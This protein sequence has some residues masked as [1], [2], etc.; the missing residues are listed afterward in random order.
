MAFAD[1]D[2]FSFSGRSLFITTPASAAAN[3]TFI[4]PAGWQAVGPWPQLMRNKFRAATTA[5]LV[6]NLVV[7]S[8][9]KPD[10]VSA[11]GFRLFVTPMG[12]WMA[13]R[14][15]IIKILRGIVPVYVSMMG[16]EPGGSYSV[17]LLPSSD[18]GGESYR[19]SFAFN[20]AG[21][22]T[23]MDSLDWGHTIAH[24]IFHY[25]NGWRLRGT[26][27]PSSQWFQEGF[28]DYAAD[29]AMARS[30]SMT[31][32]D[33]LRRI[34]VEIENYRKLTTPLDAPGTHKG[35]PLY[36]GGSLVALCWDIQIRNA[37]GN[38]RTLADF[39]RT[40]WQRSEHGKKTYTWSD[41]RSALDQTARLDWETFYQSFIHGQQKLP[42]A[43]SLVL[44][45]LKLVKNADGSDHVVIDL[46]AA[47]R[48][49]SL[50]KSLTGGRR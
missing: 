10:I 33:F 42:L 37:T 38:K 16:D 39:L 47:S 5:D 22:P 20:T 13:V 12:K 18:S 15:S 45:G 19:N 32:R 40:I 17:V 6:D 27:Y 11:D 21:N 14:P 7:L 9:A 44:A 48:A 4:L 26:D 41:I 2:H 28:T 3:V 50:R 36:G 43:E 1:D 8:S 29:I 31:E 35:P 25:W 49:R 24:E 46:T 30:G 34:D 23:E